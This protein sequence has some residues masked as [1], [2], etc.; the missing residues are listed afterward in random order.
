MTRPTNQVKLGGRGIIAL[1]QG[2]PEF[3]APQHIREA[4]KSAIEHNQFR[5]T[6]VADTLALRE[7]VMR[8][9]ERDNGLSYHP[10]Q[11]QVGRERSSCCATR[12]R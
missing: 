5:Y 8:K 4:A 9:F 11:I 7:A 10:D 2:E 12:S 6:D 3:P 1:S